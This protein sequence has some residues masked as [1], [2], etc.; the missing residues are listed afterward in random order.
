[1]SL[2]DGVPKIAQYLDMDRY[3]DDVRLQAAKCISKIAVSE[4][5]GYCT[6]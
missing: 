5:G 1:M 3:D 6:S 4:V 2:L